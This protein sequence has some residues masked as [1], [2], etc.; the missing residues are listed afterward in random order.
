MNEFGF[1]GIDECG[2]GTFPLVMTGVLSYD[3]SDAQL[4]ERP[5]TGSFVRLSKHRSEWYKK[6]PKERKDELCDCLQ[7]REYMHV[8]FTKEDKKILGGRNFP[9]KANIIG[10]CELIKHYNEVKE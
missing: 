2:Q 1:L 6:T 7:G 9:N 5:D 3:S 8:I 10:I 4:I